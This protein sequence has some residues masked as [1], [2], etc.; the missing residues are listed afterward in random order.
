M[1]PKKTGSGVEGFP[2]DQLGGS[3]VQN[4]VQGSGSKAEVGYVGVDFQLAEHFHF[5]ETSIG[6]LF[7]S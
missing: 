4:A 7:D 2:H 3:I 1:I 5:G 6:L